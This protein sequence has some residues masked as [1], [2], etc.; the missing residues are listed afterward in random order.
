[1]SNDLTNLFKIE[2]TL[3]EKLYNSLKFHYKL[4]RI[5]LDLNHHFISDTGAILIASN[6]KNLPKL[7]SLELQI[8]QNHIT[9]KGTKSFCKSFKKL[10]NLISIHLNLNNLLL[11]K[12]IKYIK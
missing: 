8:R 6:L 11:Q 12:G 4:K 2:E 5:L 10:T 3:V 9:S 7:K 1:M